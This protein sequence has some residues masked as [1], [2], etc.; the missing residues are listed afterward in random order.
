MTDSKGNKVSNANGQFEWT[1]PCNDPTADRLTKS[2]YIQ[3]IKSLGYNPDSA[4]IRPYGYNSSKFNFTY[5]GEHKIS[6]RLESYKM[7]VSGTN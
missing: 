2:A 5:L 1:G 7:C 6:M 4:Q 3:V